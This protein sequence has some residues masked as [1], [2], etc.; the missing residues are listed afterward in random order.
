MTIIEVYARKCETDWEQESLI[1]LADAHCDASSTLDT[2]DLA[3]QLEAALDLPA[4]ALRAY[5]V[6]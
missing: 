3:D 6:E 1:E 5:V 4:G 2:T